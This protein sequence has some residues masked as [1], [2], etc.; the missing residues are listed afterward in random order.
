MPDKATP[1]EF[2]FPLPLLDT[3][4]NYLLQAWKNHQ[5]EMDS[6]LTAAVFDHLVELHTTLFGP[7]HFAPAPLPA[8]ES[9]VSQQKNNA[10]IRG[11][12]TQEQNAGLDELEPLMGLARDSAHRAFK[13]QTVKLHND[14]QVGNHD[15]RTLGN[16]LERATIIADSCERD[17]AALQAKGWSPAETTALRNAIAATRGPDVAQVT[18]LGDQ[19]EATDARNLTA[20]DYYEGLLTVQ[21][22]A[23]IQWKAGTNI[24]VRTEFRLDA[25][26][27]NIPKKAV[28]PPVPPVA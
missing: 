11:G 16:I 9:E 8:D 23:K 19:I 6:R 3:E 18:A 10:S 14:Y 4:G 24:G 17:A 13:K 20:N 12:L 27:P 25:F 15:S 21:N 2:K 26:P 7:P 28:T 22:A 1:L 5:V